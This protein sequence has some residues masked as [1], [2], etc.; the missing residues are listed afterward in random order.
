MVKLTPD[1]GGKVN[2]VKVNPLLDKDG[3]PRRNISRSC[4]PEVMDAPA[5]P[6]RNTH[7]STRVARNFFM[8]INVTVLLRD[9]KPAPGGQV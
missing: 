3:E 2:K 1:T 7:K 8:R 6:A 5:N 9:Y 4:A